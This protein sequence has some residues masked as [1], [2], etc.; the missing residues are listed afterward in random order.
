MKTTNKKS[1]LS[2]LKRQK[3][4]LLKSDCKTYEEFVRLQN[5]LDEVEMKLKLVG[6]D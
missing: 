1:K 6:G 3:T 4:I 2:S 5:K